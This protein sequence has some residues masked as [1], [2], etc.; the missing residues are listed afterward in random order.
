MYYIRIYSSTTEEVKH[1]FPPVSP[2]QYHA[3]AMRI[4]NL[5]GNTMYESAYGGITPYILHVTKAGDGNFL[6]CSSINEDTYN[7]IVTYLLG[8][9]GNHVGSKSKSL[10]YPYHLGIHFNY[11]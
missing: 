9:H 7:I 5:L 10:G 4:K 11:L 3:I 1:D 6:F 2:E 8:E